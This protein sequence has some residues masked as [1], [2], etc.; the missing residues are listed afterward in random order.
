MMTHR[1]YDYIVIDTVVTLG[2]IVVS[3]LAIGLKFQEF[4]PGRGR[5]I[6]KGNKI[7][8]TTFFGGE[9]KPLI[10]CR[11]ILQNLQV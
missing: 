8:G 6:F 5:W 10:P 4:K 11:K 7:R 1:V 3:L 2:G 9:V